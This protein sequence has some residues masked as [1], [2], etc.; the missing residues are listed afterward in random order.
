M[1]VSAIIGIL[2]GIVAGL[3]PGFGIFTS[4]IVLYPFLLN[5]D[6]INMSEQL[7]V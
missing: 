5:L 1:I 3:I 6:P 7:N 4:L 2:I